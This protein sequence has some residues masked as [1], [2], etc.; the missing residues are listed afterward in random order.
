MDQQQKQIELA[1]Q[2]LGK[3][4]TGQ[5]MVL[6]K[7]VLSARP[8]YAEMRW[9]YGKA[10]ISIQDY[11]QAKLQLLKTV[12]LAP[13]NPHA[14]F[15]LAVCLMY[16]HDYESAMQ[17]MRTTL[18][19]MP[20][21]A[22]ATR[23]LGNVLLHHGRLSEAAQVLIE[24]TRYHPKELNLWLLLGNTLG[25]LGRFDESVDCFKKVL[26]INPNIQSA[27]SNILMRMNYSS[28][29]PPSEIYRQS[30]EYGEAY[31]RKTTARNQEKIFHS[32][33][34]IRVGYV[35]S[36][37]RSHSVAYFL[38]PLLANHDR[39]KIELFIYSNTDHSDEM[40]EQFK[41]YCDH[42]HDIQLLSDDDVS[43][44]ITKDGIHILV[45][46]ISHTGGCRFGVFAQA[47]APIQVTWLAYP[48]TSGVKEI[49]YRFTDTI[50][51]PEGLTDKYYTEELI[52]LPHGFLCYDFSSDTPYR[53]KPPFND[54]GY[55][56]FGSFNN[57][58]KVAG[59][60]VAAWATILK[61]VPNSRILIKSRQLV[62]PVVRENYKK[63]FLSEGLEIDRVE[64]RDAVKGR[65]KHL[66]MYD[67]IDIALDT[68]PYNG[69]TTT[70]EALWMGV[71]TVTYS[72]EVHASRVGASIM[73]YAGVKQFVANSAEQYIDLAVKLG[74]QPEVLNTLRPELRDQL[75][76][77]TLADGACFAKQIEN[78]Y[79]SLVERHFQK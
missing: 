66:S 15:E 70:C 60:N 20:E 21:H 24:G 39:S 47:P 38:K 37:L 55:I 35:S 78:T 72:G 25:D 50:A 3:G 42:W 6:F 31:D 30:K 14:H 29:F 49:Q 63:M 10:L 48:N 77:S 4:Q 1:R 67:D 54:N 44:L 11:N 56:T 22:S 79:Q 13:R 16:L 65:E 9:L 74:N 7:Q 61:G 2:L 19:Y 46:V 57:L 71:P 17:S 28:D 27:K 68:F 36:N 51:D 58:N 41:R 59:S 64:F 34:K 8:D 45:D 62:D 18:Q 52:R 33:E 69:T 32:G 5:A 12:Q 40:T 73:H 23:E 75:S 53:K 43:A 76:K 26:D